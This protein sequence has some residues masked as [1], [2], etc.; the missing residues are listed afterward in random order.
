MGSACTKS[1]P[2]KGIHQDNQREVSTKPEILEDGKNE[3]VD[4]VDAKK[5]EKGSYAYDYNRTIRQT[6]QLPPNKYLKFLNNLET[7][8]SHT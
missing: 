6:F 1:E 5:K 8:K 3:T 2:D 7:A 4:M